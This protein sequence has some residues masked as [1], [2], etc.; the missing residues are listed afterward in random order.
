MA[1][2]RHSN[3]KWP[4][5]RFTVIRR[6]LYDAIPVILFRIATFRCVMQAPIRLS[7]K[8][9]CEREGLSEALWS[10]QSNVSPTNCRLHGGFLTIP[11]GFL[12]Q[13]SKDMAT[14][15]KLVSSFMHEIEVMQLWSLLR[16][17]DGWLHN[18]WRY[19]AWY[20]KARP[21]SYQQPF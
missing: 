3:I 12:L 10:Y 21:N 8:G 6:L 9:N 4:G 2:G 13:G 7:S 14:G 17:L 15:W 19:W 16:Y 18:G 20:Q 5:R 11:T 1:D